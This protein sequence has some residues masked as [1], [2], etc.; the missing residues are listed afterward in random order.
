MRYTLRT[1]WALAALLFFPMG[2]ATAAV[3]VS[4]VSLTPNSITFDLAGT[5]EGPSPGTFNQQIFITAATG[6]FMLDHVSTGTAVTF[7]TTNANGLFDFYTINQPGRYPFTLATAANSSY[8]VGGD[9]TGTY[10]ATWTNAQ[11]DPTGG[12]TLDFHWGAAGVF[13]T[14]PPTG[15]AMALGVP[16]PEPTASVFTALG[17]FT[18]LGRRR[19][20]Q[21][22]EQ[23]GGGVA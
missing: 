4:N 18:L 22:A 6:S 16:I 13:A 11:F 7:S 14:N 15:T 23:A 20:N 10:S 12:A 8:V 9:V 17:L 2:A 1:F 3:V 19:R 5:L 21:R